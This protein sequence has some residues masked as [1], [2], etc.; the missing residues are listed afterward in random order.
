MK[1]T[2]LANLV[3]YVLRDVHSDLAASDGPHYQYDP[4]DPRAVEILLKFLAEELGSD[5]HYIDPSMH[6]TYQK[7]STEGYN[8]GLTYASGILAGLQPCSFD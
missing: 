8:D 7:E 5:V 2:K 4:G 1:Y 3:S 6:L